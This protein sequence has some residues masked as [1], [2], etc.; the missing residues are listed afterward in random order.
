M[1]G[2]LMRLQELSNKSKPAPTRLEGAQV[3]RENL[4]RRR[5][6]KISKKGDNWSYGPLFGLAKKPYHGGFF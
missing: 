2:C 6:A 5:V 1:N 3:A 4:I